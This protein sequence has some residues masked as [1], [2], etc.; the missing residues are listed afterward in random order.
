M[1]IINPTIIQFSSVR[2]HKIVN[3]MCGWLRMFLCTKCLQVMLIL[4]KWCWNIIRASLNAALNCSGGQ[5]IFLCRVI[6]LFFQLCL[7]FKRNSLYRSGIIADTTRS[8]SLT[9]ACFRA[10]VIVSSG[11][12]LPHHAL[13][14]WQSFFA[15][16]PAFVPSWTLTGPANQMIQGV[17]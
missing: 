6:K 7:L 17:D 14:L 15:S 12:D 9:C 1:T 4:Q 2:N 5:D 13:G 16:H 8:S 3:T 10:L 11:L